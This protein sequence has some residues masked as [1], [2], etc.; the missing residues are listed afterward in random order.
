[1]SASRNSSY[2]DDDEE[3]FEGGRPVT[4]RIREVNDD[5]NE[6]GM[7]DVHG[8]KDDDDDDIGSSETDTQI[9][10][11]HILGPANCYY[12][13]DDD[14]EDGDGCAS[15]RLCCVSRKA[16][17]IFVLVCLMIM[18]TILITTSM[19]LSK[20]PRSQTI[21]VSDG[22]I[23]GVDNGSTDPPTSSPTMSERFQQFYVYI[24]PFSGDRLDD[25][26]SPQFQALKWLVYG[27]EANLDPD[28]STA[29]YSILQRY[30]LATLY[31]STDGENWLQL[32]D[33]FLSPDPVC[34]WNAN[35]LGTFCDS[36][37]SVTRVSIGT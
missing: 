3:L 35:D 17:G 12:G 31:Y 21:T 25:E 7:Y 16:R 2:H 5:N 29:N 19:M 22:V 14:D 30:A 18:A 32:S 28:K 24:F 26:N 6:H 4:I 34:S 9:S 27:D 11:M 8:F 20:E 36:N 37:G 13:D 10:T 15:G 1:M 23:A 33:T